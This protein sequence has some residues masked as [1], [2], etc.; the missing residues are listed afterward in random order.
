MGKTLKDIARELNLSVSTVSRVVNGRDNVNGKTREMIAEYLKQHKYTPNQVARSLKGNTTK[1]IGIIVPDICEVFFGQ[2]IKGIDQVVSRND[3]SIILV[4]SH[5]DKHKEERYLELLYRQRVDGLVVATVNLNAIKINDFIN[6]E[7]PVVFIDNLPNL[8]FPFDAI[9]TDNIAA[10]KMAVDHL[11]ENGHRRIAVIVGSPEETTGADRLNGY[12]QA[13]QSAGIPV[14]ESLI[15][16]GDYKEKS[17]YLCMKKLLDNRAKSPFT[18]VYVMAEMMTVGAI[19]AIRD[20]GLSIPEEIAIVG[21]DVHDK[22]DL[23]NPGISTIRQQEQKMGQMVGELLMK[24]LG[25]HGEGDTAPKQKTLL[26]PY[27]EIKESSVKKTSAVL[28]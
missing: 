17:G 2:I 18:A 11:L 10:S 6:D 13:L 19:K 16:F 8:Q 4:D 3:Y 24:R 22:A 28:C 27:L 26:T 15:T 12:R 21:F 7:K 5:E 14:D 25:E 9:L 20:A 1:T 23:M